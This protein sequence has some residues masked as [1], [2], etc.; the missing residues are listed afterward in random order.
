MEEAAKCRC[1]GAVP[2]RG[3]GV[4]SAETLWPTELCVVPGSE[5]PE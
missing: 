2:G 5:G 3:Q 4:V 1:E